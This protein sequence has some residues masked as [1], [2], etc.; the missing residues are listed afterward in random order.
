MA[1]AME[2]SSRRSGRP[3][4]GQNAAGRMPMETMTWLIYG[5]PISG[6]RIGI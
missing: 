5:C 1:K 3:R 6:A 2:T 4:I